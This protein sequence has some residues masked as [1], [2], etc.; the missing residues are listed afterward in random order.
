MLVDTQYHISSCSIFLQRT[1]YMIPYL[2]FLSDKFMAAWSL[3]RS[4]WDHLADFWVVCW[5][6]P[7]VTWIGLP[8]VGRVAVPPWLE[9]FWSE[10]T[11]FNVVAVILALDFRD[12]DLTIPA[13]LDLMVPLEQVWALPLP[14]SVKH[15]LQSLIAS[16]LVEELPAWV[17]K[18]GSL[19]GKRRDLSCWG[20]SWGPEPEPGGRLTLAAW[21]TVQSQVWSDPDLVTGAGP[22][23]FSYLGHTGG[24]LEGSELGFYNIIKN[25]D[26]FIL[27]KKF[28]HSGII[29]M[30][31]KF[32]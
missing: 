32:Q 23:T 27:L 24:F 13:K 6:L 15:W 3:F 25:Y 20:S 29:C 26:N 2:I 12:L 22:L 10:N 18:G 19:C 14:I 11:A 21:Q 5:D 1:L 4:P 16:G 8:P 9:I 31:C 17:G 30:H 28:L 7:R